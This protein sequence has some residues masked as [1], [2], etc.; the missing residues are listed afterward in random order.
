MSGIP[1]TPKERFT[2]LLRDGFAC[3]YC[4]ARSPEARLHVDH[5][6]PR[7]KGGDNHE[8]NLVTACEPCNQGKAT[9]DLPPHWWTL[10]DDALWG[11]IA[12]RALER[13]QDTV[14]PLAL[15]DILNLANDWTILGRLERAES[16]QALVQERLA[17]NEAENALWEAEHLES[18]SPE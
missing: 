12:F 5:V 7:A 10:R 17:E 3:V 6:I 13:F 16:L 1:L 8:S 15:F 9:T 11:R 18:A 4:G 2:I 14:T